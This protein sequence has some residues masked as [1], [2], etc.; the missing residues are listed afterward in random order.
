M[1]NSNNLSMA[2]SSVGSASLLVAERS[3]I[4]LKLWRCFSSGR[5]IV[6]VSGSESKGGRFEAKIRLTVSGE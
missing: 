3:A 5:G 2:S 1:F 6:Y 4:A